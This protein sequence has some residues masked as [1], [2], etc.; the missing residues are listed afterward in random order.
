MN[1]RTALYLNLTRRTPIGRP[2]RPPPRWRPTGMHGPTCAFW[3]SLMHLCRSQVHFAQGDRF[4]PDGAP[5]ARSHCCF[6]LSPIHFI[7]DSLTYSVPL[8]LKRQCDRTL[9]DPP[10]RTETVAIRARGPVWL[11]AAG[12][13]GWYSHFHAALFI[14]Y[15]LPL[16]KY[17]G[18]R[19]NDF[20]THG[21]IARDLRHPAG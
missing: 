8:F 17:T 16:M 3:A 21:R 10:M 19:E 2:T 13:H 5:R 6:V 12:S 9:G 15:R 7:P 14:L 1:A 11:N 20:T 18:E 4:T